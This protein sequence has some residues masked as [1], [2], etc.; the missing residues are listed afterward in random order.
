[1]TKEQF[2]IIIYQKLED[3]YQIMVPQ[4]F[5]PIHYGLTVETRLLTE[6]LREHF[7]YILLRSE[8]S[9]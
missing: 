7:R 2:L 1:M 9:S 8:V 3:V 4:G 6:R 5:N